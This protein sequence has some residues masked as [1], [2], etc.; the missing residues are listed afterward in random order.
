VFVGCRIAPGQSA[1]DGRALSRLANE[2]QLDDPRDAGGAHPGA[3]AQIVVAKKGPTMCMA[4]SFFPGPGISRA[5]GDGPVR[6]DLLWA[7]GRGLILPRGSPDGSRRRPVRS[8][9]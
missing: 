6:E 9:G 1:P 2:G 8:V 5:R 7:W 4:T 3:S